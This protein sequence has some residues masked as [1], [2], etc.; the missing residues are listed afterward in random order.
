MNHQ[1]QLLEVLWKK[2]G[3]GLQDSDILLCCQRLFYQQEVAKWSLEKV[4]QLEPDVDRGKLLHRLLSHSVLFALSHLLDQ[5]NETELSEL[6]KRFP[7]SE[8]EE[9]AARERELTVYR[10]FLVLRAVIKLLRRSA[11]ESLDQKTID[12]ASLEI[13]GYLRDLFPFTFRLELLESIFSLLFMVQ[14]DLSS[15]SA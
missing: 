9:S 1:A 8:D 11:T 14:Q 12:A 13:A 2:Q 7:K 4:E 15:L 3:A 10:G 5:I 6:L